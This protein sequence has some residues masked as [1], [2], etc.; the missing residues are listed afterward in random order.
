MSTDF[1]QQ[2]GLT[3]IELVVFIVIVGVG[4]AGVLMALDLSTRN[5]VDPLIVKQL[6][7][8][9]ESILE[10]V[11]AQPFNWCDPDDPNAASATSI[12]SCSLNAAEGSGKAT[13]NNVAETRGSAASPLDNVSDYHGETILSTISGSNTGWP[14]DYQASITVAQN[15]L[16]NVPATESLLISVS[17]SHGTQTLTLQGYRLRH[18][19]TALP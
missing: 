9:A 1:R 16:N 18:S 10:E 7:A 8:I 3:L 14:A 13:Y 15:S 12:N 11:I 2:R 19:P 4:L 17:A 5:S 6:Q